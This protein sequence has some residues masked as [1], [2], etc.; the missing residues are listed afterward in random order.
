LL[1]NVSKDP[2]PTS[3]VW[4]DRDRILAGRQIEAAKKVL[5]HARVRLFKAVG[6]P[7]Q[8][9]ATES[10]SKLSLDFLRSEPAVRAKEAT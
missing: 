8:V 4:G 6:H 7:P 3:V 2:H 5:P 9:E 1:C 10:I